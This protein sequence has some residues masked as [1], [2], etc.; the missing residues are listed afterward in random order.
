MLR[1]RQA[2]ILQSLLL[3]GL[4]VAAEAMVSAHA[5]EHDP[6]NAQN[7]VCTTC[8]V[9]S[10]LGSACVD[11]TALPDRAQFAAATAADTDCSFHSAQAPAIRQRGPPSPL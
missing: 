7:P 10:L 11:T 6:N 3:A 1:R 8:V 2:S 4:L 9:A 5:L